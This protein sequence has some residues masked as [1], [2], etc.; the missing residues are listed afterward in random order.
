[1]FGDSNLLMGNQLYLKP[2]ILIG[3]QHLTLNLRYEL[4]AIL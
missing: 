2:L 1:M 4:V 3:F